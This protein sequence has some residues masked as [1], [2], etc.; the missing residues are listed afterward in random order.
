MVEWRPPARS[1]GAIRRSRKPSGSHPP[2][3][4]LGALAD[5]VYG[6]ETVTLSEDDTVVLYTDGVTEARNGHVFFG[7]DRV[8]ESV[9]AGGTPAEHGEATAH[10]GSAVRT[11]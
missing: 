11:R 4:C 3:R 6:E 2:A 7:E 8:K 9:M 10:R 1:H 5:V